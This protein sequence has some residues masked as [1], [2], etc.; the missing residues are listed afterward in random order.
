MKPELTVLRA[1]LE[2]TEAELRRV[3][4]RLRESEHRAAIAEESCRDAWGF[5]RIVMRR[6]PER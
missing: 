3:R 1:K 2:R 5:S 4:E 6:P